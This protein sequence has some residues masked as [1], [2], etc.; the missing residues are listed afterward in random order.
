MSNHCDYHCNAQYKYFDAVTRRWVPCPDHSKELL[1]EVKTGITTD[2]QS[3]SELLGFNTEYTTSRLD[4]DSVLSPTEKR[5]LNTESVE[6]FTERLQDIYNGLLLGT[7]PKVSWCIGLDRTFQA[8]KVYMPLMLTAYKAGF[9]VAPV[10]SATEYRVRTVSEERSNREHDRFD[11]FRETYLNADF[12]VVI[13]PSGISEGDVLEA[14]GLMQ[15]R[16]VRGKGTVLLTSRPF[17]LMTE[18]VAVDDEASLF[19]ARSCMVSYAHQ[20]GTDTDSPRRSN[21]VRLT[22]LQDILKG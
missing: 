16:A 12:C 10:I 5:K 7:V 21:D 3:L 9:S 15:S 2:G 14:K 17:E 22:S 13:V 1:D 18:V 11:N 20:Q 19:M 6:L 4:V 8:D